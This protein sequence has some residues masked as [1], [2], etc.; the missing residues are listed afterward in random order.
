MIRV[1]HLEFGRHLYGGAL[2]VAYLV[3]GLARSQPS[4]QNHLAAPADNPLLDEVPESPLVIRHPLRFKGEADPRVLLELGRIVRRHQPGLVH[5]H[6]RRGADFW[7]VLLARRWKLPFV[8]TRRVVYPESA[9]LV[10][11]KARRSSGV[12]AISTRVREMMREAGVPEER[13]QLIF[14]TVD[15]ETYRPEKDPAYFREVTGL[16]P[17]T[18]TVALIAQMIQRKGHTY[19]FQAIPEVLSGH[20]ETHFLIFGQGPLEAELKQAVARQPWHGRVRFMGFRKDLD[21][22]LPCIDIVVHPALFEA[23]GVALLQAAACGVPIVAS[24]AGGIPDIVRDGE[25]GFLVPPGDTVALAEALTRLLRDP[26]LRTR[27]GAQGRVFAETRFSVARMS[28][29]Y[30]QLYRRI[31]E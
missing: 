18:P 9:W 10:R 13:L 11:W 22:L 5:I 7:G 15:L 27:L 8:L 28:A 14:S 17:E 19:L 23:L 2:Q 24:R 30:A 3:R 25:N 6:S 4:I 12:V 31:L 21:R 16:G 29:D 20:P 1:L 26:G